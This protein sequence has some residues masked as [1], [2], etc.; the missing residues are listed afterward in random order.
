MIYMRHIEIN[1]Y[2]LS[3]R[4]WED[5]VY[6]KSDLYMPPC[7]FRLDDNSISHNKLKEDAFFYR[8]VKMLTR[9]WLS[10]L[11]LEGTNPLP[12]SV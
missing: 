11:L 3:N 9:A 10:Y 1:M 8:Q 6:E 7:M 2:S 12:E 5:I 4:K